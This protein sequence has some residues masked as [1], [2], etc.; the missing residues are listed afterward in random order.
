LHEKIYLPQND[1]V[2]H[3][4]IFSRGRTILGR[5]MS[6]WWRQRITIPGY[7]SFMSIEGFWS[8][9][10]T[11]DERCRHLDGF[12]AKKAGKPVTRPR[13]ADQEFR[14]LI[15]R[16]IR[17]KV[18]GA[19]I[20]AGYLAE[21]V[22]PLTHYYVFHDTVRDAGHGWIVDEWERIRTELRERTDEQ[23]DDS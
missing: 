19:P 16:A 18:Q 7:G 17:I 14:D 20:F 22:L 12:P 4:N 5:W 11:G 10:S 2:D 23:S 8:F 9:L 1:G 15:C 13:M 3:I 21:S 6:N